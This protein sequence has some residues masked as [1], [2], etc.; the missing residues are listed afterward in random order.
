MCALVAALVSYQTGGAPRL[1]GQ[2]QAPHISVTSGASNITLAEALRSTLDRHPSIAIQRWQVTAG[3]AEKQQAS[4]QFD[5]VFTGTLG[6]QSQNIPLTRL[7][8]GQLPA[9]LQTG[10]SVTGTVA[11]NFGIS[12]Q[13]RNG[14][15]I[16]T[17][18]DINRTTDNLFNRT[19]MNLSQS[20]VQLTLP[21]LQGKG[22]QFTAAKEQAAIMETRSRQMDLHHAAEQLL[23][24]TA[25][26]YWGLVAAK[27]NLE[28]AAETEERSRLLLQT[29]IALIEADQRPQNDVYQVKA[30]LA[31]RTAERIS[32]EETLRRARRQLAVAMGLS[33]G[34]ILTVGDAKDGFPAVRERV[35]APDEGL[36]EQFVL[37]ALQRRADVAAARERSARAKVLL[38][39]ANQS[40]KPRLDLQISSGYT[41][42]MEG[43]AFGNFFGSWFSNLHRP[44]FQTG[45]SYQFPRA[46]NVA[47]GQ[48]LEAS[49]QNRIAD[50][51]LED[52]ERQ[53]AASVATAAENAQAAVLRLQCT[54]EAVTAFR[55]TLDGER[56]KYRLGQ[57][58]L[59]ELLTVEDQLTA[60]LISRVQAQLDYAVALANLRL[61]T[62]TVLRSED[63]IGVDPGTFETLP[64][65]E[66]ETRP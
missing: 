42:L 29:V 26:S 39:A 2:T 4:G 49:A 45:V 23:S 7:Q 20:G 19:G 25:I 16:S 58:S 3:Q 27:K 61:A 30:S 36:V 55:K 59:T 5:T 10:D 46:N 66:V 15:S 62:G 28:V 34:E 51:Q 6:R 18:T 37:A 41:Q 65:E 14:I 22:R 9:D 38:R 12:K 1:F 48:F 54:G 50:L 64:Y 11:T 21:L 32:A 44:D 24:D 63:A 53:V 33:A 17:F 40:T 52:T 35:W 47:Q 56:E 57:I 8:L 13:F 60:A 31:M 43:R